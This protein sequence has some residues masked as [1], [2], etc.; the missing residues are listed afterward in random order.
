MPDYFSSVYMK[1]QKGHCGRKSEIKIDV[2]KGK[3][4]EEGKTEIPKGRRNNKST[5]D[6][7]SKDKTNKMT[8][9]TTTAAATTKRA[10]T[11]T[12]ITT[13]STRKRLQKNDTW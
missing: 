13:T 5:L 12:T 4:R 8:T 10:T 11:A 2:E 3:E 7:K 1:K 6:K 9:A